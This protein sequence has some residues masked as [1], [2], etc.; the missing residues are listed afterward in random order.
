MNQSITQLQW[1]HARIEELLE[2][3]FLCG[4]WYV[5]VESVVLY[6]YLPVIAR[7]WFCKRV[8]GATK[9]CWR[10][11]I[12]FGPCCII[13]SMWLVLPTTS[14]YLGKI[15]GIWRLKVCYCF[16]ALQA[17]NKCFDRIWVFFKFKYWG[18]ARK[19]FLSQNW[20]KALL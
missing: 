18:L 2:A 11:H 9:N 12:L 3:S 13:G 8:L 4:P 1:I 14:C 17:I 7:Q 6:V 19:V 15:Q 20:L 5:R 16:M 10:C